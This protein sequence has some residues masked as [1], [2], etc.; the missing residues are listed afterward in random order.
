MPGQP[1]GPHFSDVHYNQQQRESEERCR[2]ADS[3][4]CVTSGDILAQSIN[5]GIPMTRF[6]L[7][8]LMFV[9][10]T[11]SSAQARIHRIWTFQDLLEKADVV[12]VASAID[13]NDS[14]NIDAFRRDYLN[15]VE[16]TLEVR[17]TLKGRIKAKAQLKL[18]HFRMKD[19]VTVKRGP[20]LV[21]INGPGLVHFRTG[22]K[23]PSYLL[24]LKRR[25]DGK[26]EAVSGQMDP[27]DSVK[28]LASPD[29]FPP[30]G[31]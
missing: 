1:G 27:I 12:F 21:H 19:G 2:Q 8:P 22:K 4:D 9:M 23:G 30:L 26:Y 20:R 11:V 7:L 29:E 24:F 16:T 15:Q 5:K 6:V 10:L 3:A 13:S 17:S 14:K 25:E 31:K 18:V 28:L